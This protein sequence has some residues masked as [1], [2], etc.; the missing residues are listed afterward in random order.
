MRVSRI[1]PCA[2]RPVPLHFRRP[3]GRDGRPPD[4]LRHARLVQRAGSDGSGRYRPS[5][6][7]QVADSVHALLRRIPYLA[8]NP[9]DRND[10]RGGSYGPARPSGARRVPRPRP[11]SRK[12]GHA[13]HGPE[14]R[15]L[16]PDPRGVEQVLRRDS[17]S[18]G[19]RHAQHQPHHRPRIQAVHLLRRSGCRKHR[20]GDG[21]RL[22]NAQGND[23]LHAFPR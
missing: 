14:P 8:R 23:R 15:H 7:D 3:S 12:S 6:V 18:G 4:R 2:G 21:F 9:E 10:R 19:R 22:R 11:Q 1:G 20:R 16:F 17:R 5:G 13:R